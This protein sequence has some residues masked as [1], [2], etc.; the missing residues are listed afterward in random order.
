MR[1][2]ARALAANEVA[3]GG[4]HAALARRHAIA[5]E[6][7]AHRAAGLA[8]L[9]ARLL[10]DAVE[11]P[12]LGLA[13]DGLRA[14]HNPGRYPRRHLPAPRPRRPLLHHANSPAGARAAEHPAL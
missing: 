2:R 4:R 10:E 14:R 3:V 5:V 8:P 9:E 13:L 6:R 1:A 12:G 7:E 11:P